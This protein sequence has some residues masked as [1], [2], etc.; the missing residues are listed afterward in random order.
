MILN[1]ALSVNSQITN[2]IPLCD[3]E[4]HGI[5]L[6]KLRIQNR[7]R[8]DTTVTRRSFCDFFFFLYSFLHHPPPPANTSF[9]PLSLFSSP[10][11]LSFLIRIFHKTPRYVT[12]SILML[13][14][15]VQI[16]SATVSSH[17]LQNLYFRHRKR[18]DFKE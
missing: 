13:F 7:T 6:G 14:N 18:P 17:L 2:L 12:C 8:E 15:P 3:K 1:S 9:I 16:L 5:L 11:P 10:S 4:G